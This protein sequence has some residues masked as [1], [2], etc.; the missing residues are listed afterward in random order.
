MLKASIMQWCAGTAVTALISAA[1]VSTVGEF[2]VTVY[3]P[4]GGETSAI[5]FYV[6]EKV[7]DTYLPVVGR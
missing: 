1:D 3:D 5:N 2:P 6:W 7:Y 4:A